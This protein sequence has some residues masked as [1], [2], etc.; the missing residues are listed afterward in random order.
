MVEQLIR[1]EQ[2]EGSI[3][4][5][6]STSE[7][8]SLCSDDFF[9]LK[10]K[11]MSSPAA[12]R[13]FRRDSSSEKR[14]FPPPRGFRPAGGVLFLFSPMLASLAKGQGQSHSIGWRS[15]RALL[16]FSF[17]IP[18]SSLPFS[19]SAPTQRTSFFLRGRRF[20]LLVGAAPAARKRSR[21]FADCTCSRRRFFVS[22]KTRRSP[23]PSRLLFGEK[24][25]PAAS[26]LSPCGRRSLS[27]FSDAR[28]ARKTSRSKPFY[29]L[30]RFA[31]L[32][33]FLI[34]HS[35][36]PFLRAFLNFSFLIL[37]CPCPAPPGSL[38]FAQRNLLF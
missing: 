7:Q 24:T 4:F 23:V 22:Q 25:V 36:L 35:S 19:R 11:K 26:G 30:A 12:T 29:S 31:R 3:P 6:S 16:N 13:S 33:Q 14:P 37:H 2:V 32:P 1:N 18:H 8:S 5:T 15:L 34:S 21:A 38:F 28:F 17:L 27:L 10:N 20:F 9:C